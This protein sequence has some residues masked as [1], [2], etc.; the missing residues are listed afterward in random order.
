VRVKLN[1]WARMRR[2]GNSAK[3]PTTEDSF[4]R[5]EKDR[6]IDRLQFELDEY[7]LALALAKDFRKARPAS[8]LIQ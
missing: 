1:S 5:A 7:R 3:S 2:S 4:R 8:D 6:E